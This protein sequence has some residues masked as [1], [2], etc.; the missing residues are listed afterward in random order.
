MHYTS[1]I[2]PPKITSVAELHSPAL[3]HWQVFKKNHNF[4]A[5]LHHNLSTF[6]NALQTDLT[7][8]FLCMWITEKYLQ[9]NISPVQWS[10]LAKHV[11]QC[12]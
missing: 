8:S 7:M 11:H 9:C 5:K 10:R 2:F 6:L 12:S 1:H 3:L 4:Q